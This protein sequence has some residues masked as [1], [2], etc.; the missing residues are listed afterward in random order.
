MPGA[1]PAAAV[2]SFLRPLREAIS[3]VGG[4]HFTLTPGARGAVGDT[5]MWVLNDDEP[6]VVSPKLQF[7]ACMHFETLD[8]GASRA[9]ERFKVS[10]RGYMY[11]VLSPA[12]EELLAAHW[13][14]NGSSPFREPHWHV[15]SAALSPSGVFLERAHI[16]SE[17]ITLERIV[18]MVIEQ[19]GAEPAC[20]DW[21]D[22]LERTERDFHEHK[23]W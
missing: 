20:E 17:R 13:H 2:E 8:R 23:S 18:R 22:R 19:F 10:T 1:S 7:R 15:G 16:P 9:R 4:A 11:S 5:H 21:S 6:L 3:C 14:P 12:H